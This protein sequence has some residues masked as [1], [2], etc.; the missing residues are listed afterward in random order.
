MPKDYHKLSPRWC[1]TGALPIGA[2][3]PHKEYPTGLFSL[4]AS[5]PPGFLSLL[6]DIV[7]N[8]WE[9]GFQVFSSSNSLLHFQP[10]KEY[11][12][13]IFFV[14]RAFSS[15]IFWTE[16][17][18]RLISEADKLDQFYSWLFAHSMLVRIFQREMKERKI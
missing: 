11:I 2:A 17:N 5:L 6:D 9:S 1:L 8:P 18:D 13:Q 4:T 10:D 16:I 14:G 12:R 15:E 7:I 3:H